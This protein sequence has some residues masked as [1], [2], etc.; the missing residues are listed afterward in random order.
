M[1]SISI[2]ERVLV[3]VLVTVAMYTLVPIIERMTRDHGGI[4]K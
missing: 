3:E 2:A 4:D 1:K